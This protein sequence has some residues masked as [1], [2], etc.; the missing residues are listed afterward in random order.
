MSMTNDPIFEQGYAYIIVNEGGWSDHPLDPGGATNQGITKRAY[1]SFIG[2]PIELEAFKNLTQMQKKYFYNV[3]YWRAAACDKIKKPAIAIAIF[4]TTILYG[5]KTAITLA[6]V[7]INVC[8]PVLRADGVMGPE[9]LVVLNQIDQ[10][11]FITAFQDQIYRR[12]YGIIERRPSSKVFEK[13]WKNRTARLA[14][15]LQLNST[16]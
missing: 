14:K 7:A 1:E 8:G 6:Q 5:V 15:L 16:T 13:G 2:H 3:C 11:D 4:D 9:S 10:T 12:I